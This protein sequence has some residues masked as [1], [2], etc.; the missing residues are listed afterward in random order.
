M[1][2]PVW[3][4]TIYVGIAPV[5]RTTH[6]DYTGGKDARLKFGVVDDGAVGIVTCCSNKGEE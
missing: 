5:R 3:K 1:A 6:G 4:A 2:E